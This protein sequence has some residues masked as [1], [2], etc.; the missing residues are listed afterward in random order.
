MRGATQDKC[1]ADSDVAISIWRTPCGVQRICRWCDR[2]QRLFQ[3]N[4]PRAGCNCGSRGSGDFG[5]HFNLT[6]PMRGATHSR[7]CSQPIWHFNQRTPCGV[8]P[9]AWP[10]SQK[11]CPISINAPRAG[12]NSKT[13]Q[14]KRILVARR[15]YSFANYVLHI[16]KHLPT[17]CIGITLKPLI[18][19]A[20]LPVILCSLKVRTTSITLL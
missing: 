15:M 2:H 13:I 3:S 18:F 5:I 7:L 12:C 11:R 4:A 16:L 20:K 19:G 6:H 9:S 8:Q 14:S 10:H 1:P 17:Y